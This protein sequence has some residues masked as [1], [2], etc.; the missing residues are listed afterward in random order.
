MTIIETLR[1]RKGYVSSTEAM[2]MLGCTRQTLC[3][4][5][6]EGRI[7]ATRIGPTN[8]F[9]PHHLADWLTERTTGPR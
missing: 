6:N 2:E 9:D 3:R 4:W 1:S 5:V 7:S 8:K